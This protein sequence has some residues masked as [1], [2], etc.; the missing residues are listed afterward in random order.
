MTSGI[1]IF[2]RDHRLNDNLGLINFC[3]KVDTVLPIFILDENQIIK[4]KKNQY[5]FSNHAVQHMC[6]S[7][8]DLNEQL[9]KVGSKLYLFHGQPEDIIKMLRKKFD[10]IGFNADYSKYAE[11]RDN[12]IVNLFP[13]ENVFKYY[14]DYTL[15]PSDFTDHTYKQFGAYYKSAV[16]HKVSK[17]VK[18]N[19]KNYYTGKIS[20]EYDINDLNKFYEYNSELKQKGGRSLALKILMSV[21]EFKDY[22]DKRNLLTYETTNISGYLNFGAIS[23]REA[24]YS[25][26]KVKGIIKQLYWR[27]FYLQAYKSLD[28]AKDFSHMDERYNN[29]KWEN[30]KGLWK[31]LIAGKTGFLMVDAGINE[32][33]QTGYMH[34]RMRMIVGMFWTKYLLIDVFHPKYGSQVGYSKYLLDAVGPSQNLMNHRWISEFDYP[35]KKFSKSGTISG[36]PMDISNRMI[37]KFDP[38]CEYIKKWLP[39]LKN[40][41]NKDLYNWKG[42]NLHPEPIFDSK[43][44]YLKWIELCRI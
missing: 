19:H 13:N 22:E 28:G 8:V 4:N 36:R 23:I 17:P 25:F 9:K 5:Y 16:M 41:S 43:E 31:K 39:E 37:R 44:R 30:D 7:L 6:E 10:Y 32:M 11:E 3:S 12:N 24:Y 35:G 20:G 29:I 1:F 38:D 33:K 42:N 2:R 26:F 34:G 14:D 18:N 15:I 21:N 27:D 40:I